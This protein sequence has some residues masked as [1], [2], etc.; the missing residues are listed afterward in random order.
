MDIKS[1]D[2]DLMPRPS[3]D[4]FQQAIIHH[5]WASSDLEQRVHENCLTDRPP[6]DSTPLKVISHSFFPNYMFYFFRKAILTKSL[7]I[8]ICRD[9]AP[10]LICHQ[11]EDVLKVTAKLKAS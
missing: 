8:S 11:E 1:V 4:S 6:W 2:V 10:Y 9:L 7:S 5:R 3:P